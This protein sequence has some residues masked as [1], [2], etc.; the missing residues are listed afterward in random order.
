MVGGVSVLV[1][2]ILGWSWVV[3]RGGDSSENNL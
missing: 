1:R 2:W 3:I